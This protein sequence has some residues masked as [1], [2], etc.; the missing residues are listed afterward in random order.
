MIPGA[1]GERLATLREQLTGPTSRRSIPALFDQGVVSGTSFVASV[2]IG[3][4][5]GDEALGLY[6]LGLSVTLLVSSVQE[7]LVTV[8][9]TFFSRGE[10]EEERAAFAAGTLLHNVWL[11]FGATVLVVALGSALALL[12]VAEWLPPVLW[13]LGVAIPLYLLRDY[14]RRISFAHYETGRAAGMDAAASALMLG[15]LG[16]LG[17]TGRLTGVA[18]ILVLGLAHGVPASIWFLRSRD[19]FAFL[20][21]RPGELFRRHWRFARLDVS[22]QVVGIV[23]GYVVHWLLALL[24][25]PGATGILSACMTISTLSNPLILG[26]NNVFMPRVADA[27]EEGG[28]MEVW[29][30]VRK[31]TLLYLGV[32]IPITA[33]LVVFG[34]RLVA[35]IYGPAY[36]GQGHAVAVLAIGVLVWAAQMTVGNGLRALNRPEVY[37]VSGAVG[38]FVVSGAVGAIVA[39]AAGAPLSAQYGV[40]G[41]AYAILA[42]AL[43]DGIVQWV[44]FVRLIRSEVAE[45]DTG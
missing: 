4:L 15:G 14:A 21:A 28:A 16:W 8:P 31:T 30:V 27:R 42:G 12:G 43:A 37:V 44:G 35:L 23:Q 45:P 29:R 36:A 11:G 26:V 2:M 6:A 7:S 24:R 40:L 18:A 5:A 41:A 32:M 10:S 33:L 34:G 17:W 39:L 13:A 25:V 22:A 20:R 9:Y 38:L 19:R 3:R 1:V